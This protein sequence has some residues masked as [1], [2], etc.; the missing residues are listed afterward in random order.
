MVLVGKILQVFFMCVLCRAANA[1]MST[2]GSTLS[3][4]IMS[5]CT[6]IHKHVV[7]LIGDGVCAGVL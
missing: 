6:M 3:N 2:V 5:S 7:V 1:S 4:A